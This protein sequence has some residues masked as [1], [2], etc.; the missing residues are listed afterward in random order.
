MRRTKVI[1]L[2]LSL[3]MVMSTAGAFACTGVYI[4]KDVSKDGTTIVGRSEDQGSGFYSKMFKVQ[5]RVTKSGRY[6]VDEGQPLDNGKG[7]FKVKLPKTTL[8]IQNMVN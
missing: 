3:A 1:A 8:Y 2:V 7:Y 4:G 6:Y 5:P